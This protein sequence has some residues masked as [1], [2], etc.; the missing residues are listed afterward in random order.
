MRTMETCRTIA[1]VS[2][3]YDQ[4]PRTADFSHGTTK[5][6]VENFQGTACTLFKPSPHGPVIR[7][8][9]I[10]ACTLFKPLSFGTMALL[11]AHYSSHRGPVIR[12]NGIVAGRRRS[13][14]T[15]IPF[16]FQQRNAHV[17]VAIPFLN[18]KEKFKSTQIQSLVETRPPARFILPLIDFVR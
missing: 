18:L 6:Q 9:S 14:S 12:N 15:D 3:D 1:R 7:N 13:E 10:V 5:P 11:H 2:V 17:D 8:D 16:V 4:N